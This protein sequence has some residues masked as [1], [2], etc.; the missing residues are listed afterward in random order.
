[1]LVEGADDLG[2][3]LARERLA[4]GEDEHA[5]VSAQSLRDAV[6]LVRLHLQLLARPVVQLVRKEAVCATHVAHARHEDVQQHRRERLPDGQLR[7]TL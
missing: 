1:V 3:V 4:P 2:Q 7:V 5:E 6:N